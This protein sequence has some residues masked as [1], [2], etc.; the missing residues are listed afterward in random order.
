MSHETKSWIFLTVLVLIVA[1]AWAYQSYIGLQIERERT[2]RVLSLDKKQMALAGIGL[3][4][5]ECVK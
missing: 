1:G 5:L 4:P 3:T 2:Q